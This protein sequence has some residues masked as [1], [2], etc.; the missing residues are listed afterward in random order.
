[1]KIGLDVYYSHNVM[2][3]QKYKAIRK[4]NRNSLFQHQRV[5]NYIPYSDLSNY[6]NSIDIGILLPLCPDL[7][8][9]DEVQHKPV[10]MFR[11]VC[12]YI[13]RLAKF[14]LTVNEY[15]VDKL[16]VFDNIH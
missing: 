11:D 15:R 7:V 8:S 12:T 5:A 6:I 10:G 3:K 16:L 13:E 14:Y 2:G 1:M 4:A 9:V